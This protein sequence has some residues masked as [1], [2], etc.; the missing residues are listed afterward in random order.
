MSWIGA[1]LETLPTIFIENISENQSDQVKVIEFSGR[2]E[3]VISYGS[4][5]QRTYNITSGTLDA[6]ESA[7]FITFYGDHGNITPF[8]FIYESETIYVRFDG[9]YVMNG[10]VSSGVKKSV[11]FTLKEKNPSEIIL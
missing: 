5:M 11:R 1:S 6:T 4:F 3:Q 8:K 7:A 10:T 9:G 2:H